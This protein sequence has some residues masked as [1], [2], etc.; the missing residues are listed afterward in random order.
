LGVKPTWSGQLQYLTSPLYLPERDFRFLLEKFGPSLG[1]WRAAEVAA[2][3]EVVQGAMAYE[4]PVLDL[5]C[6]DGLVTSLV[7][8]RMAVA[9]D[10][11]RTALDKATSLGIYERAIPRAMEAAGLSDNSFGTIVSNSVLEHAVRIDAALESAARALRP[12]GKLVFTCPTEVFSRWLV[13][14]FKW[15][16]SGRN[17]HFQ[18]LN[19]WPVDEWER[20]LARAGLQM[21]CVRPYLTHG[22]VW[23]WDMVE[24]MQMVYWGKTRLF[25]R[26]WRR[27]P[28]AWIEALARRAARI[29]LSAP[30]PGGGRLVIA[31]KVQSL[32]PGWSNDG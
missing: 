2:L 27:L 8:S 24:L 19:L 18:H 6:G 7:F 23:I 17:R 22:W 10:P 21:V 12:G 9:L 14:P 26:A 4:E 28:P 1:L 5:G 11:D 15:Y 30:A 29:D 32:R 20:H 3:R 25:G 13:L 31:Y 16:V